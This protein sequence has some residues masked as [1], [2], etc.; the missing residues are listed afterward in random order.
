MGPSFQMS[1]AANRTPVLEAF[2]RLQDLRL[3]QRLSALDS[4]LLIVAFGGLA[5]I[6]FVT[7]G[8]ASV[9][10]VAPIVALV[11]A[12]A[13]LSIQ[14]VLQH[15]M[16]AGLLLG[17][18]CLAGYSM[19]ATFNILLAAAGMT[20]DLNA[21]ELGRASFER[22][23]APALASIQQTAD[24]YTRLAAATRSISEVSALGAASERAQ[25]GS[26]A[27]SPK[28]PGPYARLRDADE[29]Y[30]A[31]R[32]AMVAALAESTNQDQKQVRSAIASYSV[33]HHGATA[34]TI[35]SAVA[36]ARQAALDPRVHAMMSAELPERLK[37][38]DAGRRDAVTGRLVV[39]PDAA[40]KRAI[41][42][43]LAEKEPS[44]PAA[45]DAVPPPSHAS[46][47][48]GLFEAVWR[49]LSS[50]PADFSPYR[51]G[52]MLAWVPDF[53]FLLGLALYRKSRRLQR[54]LS[55]H[56][57][58]SF[59][60]LGG[61]REAAEVAARASA[62]PHLVRWASYHA[63]RRRF[64]GRDDYVL[65]PQADVDYRLLA[66]ALVRDGDAIGGDLAPGSLLPE[67]AVPRPEDPSA[68]FYFYS[69]KQGIWQRLEAD[70][71]R[72]A[73]KSIEADRAAGAQKFKSGSAPEAVAS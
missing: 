38:I 40:L 30:F 64:V 41:T 24:T 45:V 69:L 55:G 26:C 57:A 72:A 34:Q 14:L 37:E 59:G 3:L 47:T 48:A 67:G 23:V 1:G 73:A 65:V 13:L 68:F 21:A 4:S 44:A 35:E 32:A 60:A 12:I 28:G 22:S 9:A 46:A 5:N 16:R 70:A 8:V 71:M 51:W 2:K 52:L 58:E 43:V 25:G 7:T 33:E 63:V 19:V 11:G 15:K 36:A 6:I 10:P 17:S 54:S 18:G 29:E 20:A 62:D 31:D 27:P 39:C 50:Q 61:W 49:K 66:E 42:A 53:L 56:V